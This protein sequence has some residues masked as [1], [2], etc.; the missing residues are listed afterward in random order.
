M[1]QKHS[2][3]TPIPTGIGLPTH[4]SLSQYNTLREEMQPF[5]NPNT[6]ALNE[7]L[8]TRTDL[9]ASGT[10]SGTD[11]CSLTETQPVGKGQMSQNRLEVAGQFCL[12]AWRALIF[13][14]FTRLIVR[15]DR[16]PYPTPEWLESG[17]RV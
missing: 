15:V 17:V 8:T 2:S 3:P 9:L 10:S 4:L 1:T 16:V 6:P 11:I 13:F 14:V 12:H 5:L 7:F